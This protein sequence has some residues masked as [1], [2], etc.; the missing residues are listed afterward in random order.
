MRTHTSA[1]TKTPAPIGYILWSQ[2]KELTFKQESYHDVVTYKVP[3]VGTP[4]NARISKAIWNRFTSRGSI[5]GSS[6]GASSVY[7]HD[8]DLVEKTVTFS[9][10]TGIGD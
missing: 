7:I 9:I 1:T 3:F 5:I 4:D 2:R 10:S 6:Y 8:I